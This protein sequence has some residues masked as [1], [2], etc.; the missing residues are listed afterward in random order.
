VCS[1]CSEVRMDF[2]DR[3]TIMEGGRGGGAGSDTR[4][5]VWYLSSVHSREE[6]GASCT[7][8]RLP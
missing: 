3:C 5:L 1:D 6:E 4:R 2:P 8:C 7:W